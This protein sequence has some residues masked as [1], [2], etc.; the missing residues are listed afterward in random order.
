MKILVLNCGSS[1]IKYQL[2]DMEK[3]L[4]LAKGLVERIGGKESIFNY[5]RFNEQKIKT[6]KEGVNYEIALEEVLKVLQDSEKGVIKDI[7]EI[8]AIGHRVVHGG[9]H[10]FES[11]LIDKDVLK[12][13]EECIELAPLHNPANLKGIQVM[14]K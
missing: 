12:W 3:N 10:F 4:V 9:E 1:S 2:F 13:I 7:K 5:Q 14:M 6:V 8:N 11:V